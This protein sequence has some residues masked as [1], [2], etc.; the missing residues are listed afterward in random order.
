[1][2]A[3]KLTLVPLL[4]LCVT[5]ACRK[6]GAEV[7]GLIAGLPFV[8]VAILLIVVL[9][10]GPLFGARAS[11]AGVSGLAAYGAFGASYAWAA[12]R[13]AWPA[14]Y[15]A[16][17][18]AWAV[19]AYLLTF[20]HLAAPV[21][22]LVGGA[23][24]L[25]AQRLLPSAAPK[26][27]TSASRDRLLLRMA[28]GAGLTLAVSTIAKVGGGTW[29]GLLS[30]YPILGSVTLVGA[31]GAGGAGETA[32]LF[33]GMINGAWSAWICYPLLAVLLPKLPVAP[34][35]TLATCASLAAPATFLL[36]GRRR[37]ALAARAVA[38]APG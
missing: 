7:G 37:A 8:G 6:W 10:N 21:V 15:I 20:L 29:T 12:R 34:A 23:G 13:L 19:I 36:L 4:I 25:V 35:F 27:P 31:H 38:P 17:A 22:L 1:M 24:L 30:V 11:M 14:A 5:I 3:L 18:L 28:A 26:A 2:L 32:R 33:R 9:E 16:A